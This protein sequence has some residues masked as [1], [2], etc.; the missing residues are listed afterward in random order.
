MLASMQAFVKNHLETI[1]DFF[2]KYVHMG[3]LALFYFVGSYYNISKRITGI[4]YVSV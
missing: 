3:H 4:R 1:Q 2:K